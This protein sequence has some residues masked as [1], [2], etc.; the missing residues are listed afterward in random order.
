MSSECSIWQLMPAVNGH[1]LSHCVASS[2]C[3]KLT[4]TSSSLSLRAENHGDWRLTGRGVA[5]SE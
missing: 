2:H 3:H 1:T 4:A 5:N